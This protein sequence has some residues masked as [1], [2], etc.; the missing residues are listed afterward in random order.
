[1][2][3]QFEIYDHYANLAIFIFVGL[4]LSPG[5]PSLIILTGFGLILRYVYF[6]FVF[7]RFSKIPKPLD[8]SL[9]TI[10]LIVLVFALFFHLI[11]AIWMYGGD[12]LFDHT[13]SFLHQKLYSDDD[14]YFTKFWL[15][16]IKRCVDSLYLTALLIF[17]TF[18]FFLWGFLRD[19]Y[20]KCTGKTS[21]IKAFPEMLKDTVRNGGYVSGIGSERSLTKSYKI[22]NNPDYFDILA[23]IQRRQLISTIVPP[24]EPKVQP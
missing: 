6:K 2:P 18:Y 24:K 7:I 14:S 10:L 8:E 15:I 23:I 3:E 13:D 20:N 11:M 21:I 1:M 17:Y 19:I 5:M 12:E 9:N 16:L 22:Q 4:V